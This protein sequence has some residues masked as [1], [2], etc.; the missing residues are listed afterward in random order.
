MKYTKRKSGS[1]TSRSWMTK[2]FSVAQ[3]ASKALAGVQRLKQLVNVEHKI[4]DTFITSGIAATTGTLIPLSIVLQGDTYANRNGNSIKASSFEYRIRL[5]QGAVTAINQS[6]RIIF[7]QDAQFESVATTIGDVLED[8][9][10]TILNLM[11][12]QPKHTNMKRFHILADYVYPLV[13]QFA[14]NP[15]TIRYIEGHLP[16]KNHLHYSDTNP[17]TSTNTREGQI[18]AWFICDTATD[19]PSFSLYTRLKFVD[20]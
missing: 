19:Q 8:G 13:P 3:V 18:Y 14:A 4:F 2:K 7:Y 10:G 12:A 17:N 11:V 16:I 20:N 6:V 15:Q 1:K 9:A 5:L